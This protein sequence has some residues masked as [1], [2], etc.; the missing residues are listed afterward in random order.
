[1]AENHKATKLLT[2][3]KSKVKYL[4]AWRDGFDAAMSLGEVNKV[5]MEHEQPCGCDSCPRANFLRH[6]LEEWFQEIEPGIRISFRGSED[7]DG[8]DHFQG[9]V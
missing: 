2:K 7:V 9:T 6:V 3:G 5:R 1:M 8:M 4:E